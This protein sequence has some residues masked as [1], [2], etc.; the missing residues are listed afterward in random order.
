MG[1]HSAKLSGRGGQWNAP[2]GQL[3][4]SVPAGAPAVAASGAAV[5][6]PTGPPNRARAAATASRRRGGK[7]R[8]IV[9]LGV[10]VGC[11]RSSGRVKLAEW[12]RGRQETSGPRPGGAFVGAHLWA[13]LLAHPSLPQ[14][15]PAHPAS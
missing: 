4:T 12:V 10:T 15:A 11:R 5:W 9:W 2:S 13:M 7:A 14:S 1:R 6:A 3:D 8:G